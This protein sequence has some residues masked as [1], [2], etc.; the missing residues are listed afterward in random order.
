MT[1]L[2]WNERSIRADGRFLSN[3]VR[4][5]V[6]FSWNITEAETTLKELS[7][8]ADRIANQPEEDS[9]RKRL[10]T[11]SQSMNMENDLEEGQEAKSNLGR[12]R[13]PKE[14]HRPTDGLRAPC[15]PSIQP[16]SLRSITQQRRG[17]TR[18]YVEGTSNNT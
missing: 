11:L 7:G 5:T 10:L 2:D 3:L 12:L 14:S 15:P 9:S 13:A 16:T 6:L 1:S 18:G 8:E 17:L 4:T